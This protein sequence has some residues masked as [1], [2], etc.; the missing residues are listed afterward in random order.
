MRFQIAWSRRSRDNLRDF[1]KREQQQIVD[2]VHAQLEH[3]ANSENRNRKSL[4]PNGLANWELRVGNIR[5]FFDVNLI[6]SV[7]ELVAIGKK[8]HNVLRIGGEEIQP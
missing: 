8:N 4:E 5:V 6:D 3:N 2:A 1:T 7:V